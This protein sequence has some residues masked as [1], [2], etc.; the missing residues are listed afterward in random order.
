MDGGLRV[1]NWE[2]PRL[3]VS[4]DWLWRQGTPTQTPVGISDV[5][6][7]AFPVWLASQT[8]P[9]SRHLK[10]RPALWST[11]TCYQWTTKEGGKHATNLMAG[12]V[13]DP[14]CQRCS[15]LA[16]SPPIGVPVLGKRSETWRRGQGESKSD[17]GTFEQEQSSGEATE[18]EGWRPP[19]S[20]SVHREKSVDGLNVREKW[21]LKSS[22][23]HTPPDVS[24]VRCILPRTALSWFVLHLFATSIPDMLNFE[25][26]LSERS[27]RRS[28]SAV[29]SGS[30]RNFG[31]R[32]KIWMLQSWRQ[33]YTCDNFVWHIRAIS[34]SIYHLKRLLVHKVPFSGNNT[35]S[36]MFDCNHR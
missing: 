24:S 12:G 18:K 13:L 16:L 20:W 4:H 3:V 36:K 33:V 14:C 21:C 8:T 9:L 31:T 11:I 25:P 2:E 27:T 35:C 26:W 34:P 17:A 7:V 19:I 10:R 6:T 1:I 32:I 22:K 5:A 30:D 28:N 29:V 15:S 23:P